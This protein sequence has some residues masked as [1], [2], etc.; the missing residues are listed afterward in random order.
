MYINFIAEDVLDIV[1]ELEAE[2]GSGKVYTEADVG[3][4]HDLLSNQVLGVLAQEAW[5]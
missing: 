3:M 4:Y 2:S 5:N 1:N